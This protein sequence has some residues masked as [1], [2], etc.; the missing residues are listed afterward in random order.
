MWRKHG[1]TSLTLTLPKIL[2][3]PSFPHLPKKGTKLRT[4]WG[5]LI[6]SP[7]SGCEENSNY[8]I[9]EP[10]KVSFW[11]YRELRF[12]VCNTCKTICNLGSGIF[13]KLRQWHDLALICRN[14]GQSKGMKCS[15]C[16]DPASAFLGVTTSAPVGQREEIVL[17]NAVS[18]ID[19][20]ARVWLQLSQ[21]LMFIP[22]GAGLHS[23]LSGTIILTGERAGLLTEKAGTLCC[24]VQAL[25]SRYPFS[26]SR[27]WLL[28]LFYFHSYVLNSLP[29]P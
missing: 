11:Q 24:R 7:V 2:S 1:S 10:M 12:S 8:W 6:F 17:R 19:M 25:R 9:W 4:I 13:P 3:G 22:Q 26:G 18:L 16:S 29:K 27:Q 20:V 28:Y 23:H 5:P 21:K 15:A 14:K